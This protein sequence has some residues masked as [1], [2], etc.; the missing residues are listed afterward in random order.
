M[1]WP[2][3]TVQESHERTQ[4]TTS[5]DQ[6]ALLDL[7]AQM[8]LTD[9]TDRIQSVT[10]TL[11]QELIDAEAASV[12]GAGKYERSDDRTTQC[13]GT[14]PRTL[15]MTMTAGDLQLQIPKL[16]RG[17]FFP[18]LLEQRRR[19]NKAVFA[20][21]MEAYLY[22]VQRG[23]STTSTWWSARSPAATFRP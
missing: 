15:T 21:V 2:V 6:T 23:R 16:R 19:V 9:V 3:R 18:S 20:V 17:S 5:L 22:G 4:R 7:L 1:R 12:I 14:R 8:K 13:N 11:N 10:E